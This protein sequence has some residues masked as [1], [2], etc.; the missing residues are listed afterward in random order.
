MLLEDE[1]GDDQPDRASARGERCRWAVR[2]SG[3]VEAWGQL[4]H[5]EGTTNVVVTRIERLERTDLPA[6]E[7]KQIAPPIRRETGREPA[8]AAA[9]EQ[10]VAEL[11]AALPAPHSFG[12]RGR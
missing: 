2:S 10:V 11:A 4:E 3:F 1:L 6:A 5:R 7:V 12:R 8:P 9:R